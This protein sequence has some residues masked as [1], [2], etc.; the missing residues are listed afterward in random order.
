M[1]AV[2]IDTVQSRGGSNTPA[3]APS[4]TA[5]APASTKGTG[6]LSWAP[7]SGNSPLTGGFTLPGT[8]TSGPDPLHLFSSGGGGID[9]QAIQQSKLRDLANLSNHYAK[10][11]L[12]N[13]M[14][15]KLPPD[16]QAQL[17]LLTSQTTASVKST[18]Q[19]LG[20]SGSTMEASALA[21]ANTQIIAEKANMIQTQFDD[22]MQMF[23]VDLSALGQ[24]NNLVMQNNEINQQQQAQTIGGIAAI[25]E[26]IG[27]IMMAG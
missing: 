5:P 1:T 24:Q 26:A 16:M 14:S 11:F 27:S 10:T 18:F 3:P 23:G 19:G 21:Y 7:G 4:S 22:A 25:G 13:Y 8:G 2:N 12:T 17:D 9:W 20:L 15:G 6:P